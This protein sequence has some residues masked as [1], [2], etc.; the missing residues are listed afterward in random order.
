M[1]P[2]LPNYQNLHLC[3]HSG[4]KNSLKDFVS[5]AGT[6]GVSHMMI[7]T[8]TENG[9]YLRVIKNP[10]G[11]TFVFKIEEYA[12]ARDVVKF[13]QATKRHSKIFAQTLQAA[14]LLIMNGF[15]NREEND[16]FKLASLMLQSMFPPIKVQSMNLSTC[17]RVVLFNVKEDADAADEDGLGPVIEFRHYGVSAR[18]R[19]VNR[20]IKKLV[21]N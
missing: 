3:P 19:A 1:D 5:A 7:M 14:P 6:F 4:K 12:L 17:K 18:Q 20:G 9:N 15:G 8:Q 2:T 21:N 13:T 11:P 10:K 16:P